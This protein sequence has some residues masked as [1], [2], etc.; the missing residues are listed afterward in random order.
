MDRDSATK[1][2]CRAILDGKIEKAKRIMTYY[3]RSFSESGYVFRIIMCEKEH[4]IELLDHLFFLAEEK[5]P[6]E[7]KRSV[8]LDNF[9]CDISH[10][11]DSGINH[12]T[13][14]F[15]HVMERYP[16]IVKLLMKKSSIAW[17]KIN[18][19]IFER[20]SF[21]LEKHPFYFPSEGYM[22]KSFTEP[23]SRKELFQAKQMSQLEGFPGIIGRIL[24]DETDLI[25][26]RPWL[27]RKDSQ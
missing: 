7:E 4:G 3:L 11:A 16:A 19:A 8:I 2:F 15:L 17:Y 13:V 18:S 9:F 26:R 24:H 12:Q 23:L 21:I 5:F 27:K 6:D 10:Y 1:S 14:M 20:I 22:R 25:I